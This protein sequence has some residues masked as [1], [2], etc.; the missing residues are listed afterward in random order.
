[1]KFLILLLVILF[2]VWLWKRGQTQKARAPQVK[3]DATD[4]GPQTMVACLHC[5]T[6]VPEHEAVRGGSGVYCSTAHRHAS[7]D[8]PPS[9]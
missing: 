7:N 4:T 2:G 6:H 3:P 8:T 5:N 9:A 1:M